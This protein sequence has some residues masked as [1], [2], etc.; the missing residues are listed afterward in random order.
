MSSGTPSAAAAGRH[1]TDRL[2]AARRWASTFAP[3]DV[4]AACA[5]AVSGGLLLHWLSR[6]TFWRDE[7]GFLLHRR[8]WSLGTFLDPA[9]E[10]LVAIPILI[11]KLLLGVF[12]MAS[13]A[14]FQLVA[15]VTFLASVVLLFIY[16][17]ARLGAWLALA[18]ILPFS[19]SALPGTTFSSPTR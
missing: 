1:R 10:H 8:A 2:D 13:P 4:L 15:V 6:L 18:A 19:S 9:V 3:A 12:G 5:I 14:P 7:W 11:Y 17:R 16:V